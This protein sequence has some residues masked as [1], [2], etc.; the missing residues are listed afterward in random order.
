M[1]CSRSTQRTS[2]QRDR[3]PLLSLLKLGGPTAPQGKPL[4]QCKVHRPGQL[5]SL[6]CNRQTLHSG[7]RERGT[8]TVLPSGRSAKN[9]SGLFTSYKH[10]QQG[11]SASILNMTN[12]T[13][14][15]QTYKCLKT[16][17]GEV[18]KVLQ[19]SKAPV[20]NKSSKQHAATA[21]LLKSVSSPYCNNYIT[22]ISW[23]MS[24]AICICPYDWYITSNL[25]LPG[26]SILREA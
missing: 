12:E 15:F 4:F 10:T 23:E 25:L 19:I 16:T 18:F 14:L 1:F 17:C 13:T 24:K 3:Q 9:S 26:I 2:A 6:Q 21:P 11:S 5:C 7:D 8:H 20:S 22:N